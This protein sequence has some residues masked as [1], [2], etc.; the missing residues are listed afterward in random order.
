MWEVDFEEGWVKF[1]VPDHVMALGFHAGSVDV[2]FSGVQSDARPNA[3]EAAKQTT[4][5]TKPETVTPNHPCGLKGCASTSES[6]S[7]EDCDQ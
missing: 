5:S 2:D 6:I 3:K 7:C 1:R 4:N